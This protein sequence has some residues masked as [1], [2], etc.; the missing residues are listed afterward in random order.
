MRKT[1]KSKDKRNDRLEELENKWKRA[2]A[3]YQNLEKRVEA[4]RVNYI[5][6]ANSQLIIR[7]LSVADDLERAANHIKDS[8]I[9]M[10]LKQLTKT[11]KD[12]G[13]EEIKTQGE[14]FD[15][16][17]MEAIEIVDGDKDKVIAVERKGYVLNGMILRPA[18]VKVGSGKNNN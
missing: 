18:A 17:K 3:D 2:L 9:D 13:V 7:L 14:K 11:L 10:I 8:G 6:L 1:Q 4:E 12:E 5:K 15:P 16:E